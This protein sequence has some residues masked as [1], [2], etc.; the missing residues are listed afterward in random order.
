MT[1]SDA[2]PSTP[3][4]T[5]IYT[6][7]MDINDLCHSCF[8]QVE[9]L[10]NFVGM[11]IQGNELPNESWYGVLSPIAERLELLCSMQN[12]HVDSAELRLVVPTNRI[13]QGHSWPLKLSAK[14]K[15]AR[16]AAKASRRAWS[17]ELEKLKNRQV[18]R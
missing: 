9:A 3:S 7:E 5:V 14:L 15:A 18:D 16:K 12:Y 6:F 8:E 10:A 17:K 11:N 2:S 4:E 1:T 13:R